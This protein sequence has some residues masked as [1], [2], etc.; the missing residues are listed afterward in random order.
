MA[1]VGRSAHCKGFSYERKIA[2]ILSKGFKTDVER[3][4]GS[5]ATRGISTEYNHSEEIGKNGFVGDLFFPKT[6][7]MSI[8]N[9]E[10]KN[11]AG[12]K[13]VHLFN[14]NGEIP[15]FLEQVTTDSHRLGG[16]GNTVPCLII[17]VNR[18]DDYV[19]IPFRGVIYKQL[20]ENGPAM[21]TMMSYKSER[22]DKTYRYQMIVTN[23]KTFMKLNP[24]QTYEAYKDYDW[25]RLNHQEVKP[26]KINTDKLVQNFIK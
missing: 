18:E 1:T 10:L 2:K 14:S 15:S 23:L 3:T 12:V 7:P 17:H 4:V 11:H 19:V 9:Y 22:E 16:A 13:L 20:V 26:K 5:G 25:D 21:I 6:H 24:Q 8:F